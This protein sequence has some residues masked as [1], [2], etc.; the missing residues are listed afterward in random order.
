MYWKHRLRGEKIVLWAHL[1][2][3]T[4]SLIRSRA[5]VGTGVSD[6]HIPCVPGLVAGLGGAYKFKGGTGLSLGDGELCQE[7]DR[8]MRYCSKR[9]GRCADLE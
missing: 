9:K 8:D 1:A 2:S 3:V 6:S 7:G 5:A 4:H